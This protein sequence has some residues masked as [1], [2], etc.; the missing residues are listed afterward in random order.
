MCHKATLTYIERFKD[1]LEPKIL[2]VGSYDVN[3]TVR[4]AINVDVGIDMREGRGVDLVMKVEGIDR[5]FGD[6]YFKSLICVNTLEHMEDWKES[7]KSMWRATSGWLLFEL[8]T[9]DK[10]KHDYPNDYIRLTPEMILKIFP[11]V[12]NFEVTDI[13]YLWCVKKEGE[14]NLDVVPLKPKEK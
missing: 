2:E 14:L 6:G 10:L 1:R 4:N 11:N 13:T 5:F 9:P 7:L 12:H 8:P 3:G